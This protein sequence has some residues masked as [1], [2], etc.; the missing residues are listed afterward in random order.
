MCGKTGE[1]CKYPVLDHHCNADTKM[2]R[3]LVL[4]YVQGGELFDY[5]SSRGKLP[6]HEAVRLFRQMIAGLSYCHRLGICHR[7]LKPENILL[8]KDLNIK[9]A[10]F[11]M[12][13]LQANG[14]MLR[15]SCGSPH[16][17]SPEIISGY[18]YSG[19]KADIWSVGVILYA[20][21]AGTL[22]FD[23]GGDMDALMRSIRKGRYNLQPWFT[24]EASDLIRR[25][26]VVNPNERISMDEIWEHI[27]LK[28][29]ERYLYNMFGANIGLRPSPHL[30]EEECGP[31]IHSEFDIHADLLR[32]VQTLWHST[33]PKM[34]L[35]RLMSEK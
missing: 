31:R 3:Y 22:P 9:L 18:K 25:I 23:C 4:E 30:T 20:M 8:D 12:A 34:V 14:Q 13:T 26:L 6:E 11:G 7:D 28:K 2:N 21:L 5:V 17:A 1:S 27:L 35:K 15:T 10:D 33:D 19:A 24:P 16:Y 32:N 29:Y